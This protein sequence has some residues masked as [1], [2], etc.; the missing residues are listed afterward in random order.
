MLMACSPSLRTLAT[1]YQLTPKYCDSEGLK[2]SLQSMR[3][4]LLHRPAEERVS[5][6]GLSSWRLM[7]WNTFRS[8]WIRWKAFSAAN[9]LM[10][11]SWGSME[12]EEPEFPATILTRR[13]LEELKL[14]WMTSCF[15]RYSSTTAEQ[16]SKS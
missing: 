14:M 11:C 3:G 1:P 12:S 16:I 15:H 6:F 8:L 2:D 7:C 13:C 10:R 9:R 5:C 4:R